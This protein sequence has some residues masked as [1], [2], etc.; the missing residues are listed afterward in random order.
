MRVAASQQL[1]H[2]Q[3]L[4]LCMAI[5]ELIDLG[6][7]WPNYGRAAAK[8]CTSEGLAIAKVPRRAKHWQWGETLDR[9]IHPKLIRLPRLA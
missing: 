8:L 7:R 2:S 3:M 4:K 6:R 1:W 5:A 9:T